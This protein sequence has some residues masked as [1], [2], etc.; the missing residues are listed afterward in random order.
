MAKKLQFYRGPKNSMPT[1]SVG[2]PGWVTDEKRLYIGTD[3]GNAGIPNMGDLEQGGSFYVSISGSEGSYTSD[4][5]AQEIYEAY[6]ADKA[7]FAKIGEN[8]I[9]LTHVS[10][11]GS[12]Y[13]AQF[14]VIS[15]I[16]GYQNILITQSG[17]TKHVYVTANQLS[18]EE[19]TYNNETSGLAATDVQAAVDE[20][21]GKFSGFIPSSE[22]GQNNGVATLDGN[23]KLAEAQK[24]TY[25][26]S[27][28]GARPDNWTPSAQDVGAVPA[29]EKGTANGVAELDANGRVPSA[30]L[31]SYVDDVVDAYVVG[32]TPY[33]QDWLAA[34]S[35]GTALTP[36]N[37]KIYLV[38]S[39]GEYQNREYRWSGTQ[40]AQ[41]SKSLALGET[42]DTAY[43]GDHGKAAYDH[44][45][46]TSG[47]PHN[48]TAAD[49]GAMT[50]IQGDAR[51]IQVSSGGTF[52][53]DEAFGAGPYTFELDEEETSSQ[54]DAILTF[55]P[56]TVATTS[57]ASDTTYSEQ[58][59]VFRASV[60]LSGVTVSH[61]PD[62]TFGMADAVSGNLAPLAETYAGGIY[63]YAKEQ[64]TGTVTIASV[65]CVKGA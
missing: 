41:I 54:S 10:L 47:N 17:E 22:K 39:E 65:V 42:Q 48:V 35:G 4:F 37:G 59:Y 6:Q 13:S 34:E 45:Q 52:T 30:Q 25:T 19:V 56:Q 50:Q 24:P 60:A 38:V 44:S 32:S 18:G 55:G 9:P 58:G 46:K 26:A 33:T 1:L 51:Y 62:V 53:M 40:Y 49:V 16:K 27:D 5:G 23:G 8:I 21:A 64:P 14:N 63:I 29:T 61:I 3:D 7:V 12:T 36:E 11:S 2:E 20:V 15:G 31:P 57:W 28:V 43:R